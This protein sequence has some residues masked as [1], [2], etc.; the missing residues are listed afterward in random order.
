MHLIRVVLAL[1]AAA[2]ASAAAAQQAAPAPGYKIG[3]VN[4]NRVIRDSKVSKDMYGKIEAEFKKREKEIEGGPKG[5][6]ER[7]KAALAEDTDNRR[8][9]AL[10]QF[11]EKANA[12]IRRIAVAEKFDIVF[13]DA[14]YANPRI[15]LTDKV[16]REIDAG[17]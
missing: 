9:E 6:I 17:R 4:A 15:D 11:I 12:T 2:L 1:A 14:A 10:K 3:I 5:E 7:R 13:L 16:I 8:A